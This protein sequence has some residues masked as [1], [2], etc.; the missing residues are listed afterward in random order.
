MAKASAILRER[1]RSCE[2]CKGSGIETGTLT[3][4]YPCL[5]NI[6]ILTYIQRLEKLVPEIQQMEADLFAMKKVH[7]ICNSP[8]KVVEE[9]TESKNGQG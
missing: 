6:R 8:K 2:K 3:P 7:R 9:P 4:C 1:L 5:N